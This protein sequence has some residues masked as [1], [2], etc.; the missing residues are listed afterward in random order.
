MFIYI[1]ST[2]IFLYIWG[3]YIE[4]NLLIVKQYKVPCFNGKRIVFVSDF[5]IGKRDLHRLKKIVKKINKLKPDIVLS[6]GDYIKGHSGKNS[7]PIKQIAKELKEVKA[8]V[9]SVLGNHDI[10]FDKY[11]VKNTLE[12]AGI[13]V[14]NNS[15]VKYENI[16]ISGVGN[17][18]VKK[19]EISASL[20]NTDEKRILISHTPD[21]Y[22]D[23]P[24]KVD[25]ILAGH[26][27]GGQVRIPL[28][29]ALICPSKFGTK[30]SCGD[31]NE[32][33]N[34]M[35]VTAGLGTSILNVRFCCIPEVV[36]IEG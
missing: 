15:G 30:F 28:I 35:I 17:K 4:P 20:E 14:L 5:H 24:D 18:T 12:E 29:G 6:G 1:I 7:L 26:V 3:F 13:T 33:G 27:H 9:I 31:I 34:R 16:Y 21:I 11:T 32:T 19:S 2:L 23:V 25:L 8:P 22:Y 10:N 36:L